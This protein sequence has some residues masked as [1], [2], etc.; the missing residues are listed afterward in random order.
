MPRQRSAMFRRMPRMPR[1][2]ARGFTLVEVLVA[3]LMMAILATIAWQGLDSILRARD[4][5]K[6]ALDRTARLA[7]VIVQWEQDLQAL[8][9]T[10]AVPALHFDGRTVRMTR[11]A[12]AGVALVAWSMRSGQW[13]RWVGPTTTRLAD[14]QESWIASQGLLG[15]EPGHLTLAEGASEW[16][17]YFHRGGAWTNAQSTGDATA[18]VAPGG[19]PGV[20]IEALPA[21][22]RLV[23]T[24]DGKT[25]TRDVA[26]GPSGGG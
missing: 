9:E 5:S 8:Y 15:N 18:S 26:L 23:V 17:I 7:T 13:Q 14:L 2:P 16:H 20:A 4:G 19:A 6:A 25:L 3:M 10:Q 1:V 21:A 11:R 22:V 12:E 24:L